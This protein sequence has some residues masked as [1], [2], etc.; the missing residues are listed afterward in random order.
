MITKVLQ[1]D[2]SESQIIMNEWFPKGS[3]DFR[4]QLEKI[5]NSGVEAVFL[6]S[7]IGVTSEALARQI[8]EMHDW[9]PQFISHI[10]FTSSELLTNLTQVVEG[11]VIFDAPS[12]NSPEF[13]KYQDQIIASKGSLKDIGAYYTA[14]SLDALHILADL[15]KKYSENTEQM[16]NALATQVFHGWLGDIRFDG[17]SFVQGIA[18]ARFVVHSGKM[19]P[20]AQ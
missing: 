11:M 6:N 12:I 7:N 8:A 14:S 20:S 10:G 19:E 2:F 3:T 13:K 18:S 5:K 4:N 1:R 15:M 17:H 9:K 16:R